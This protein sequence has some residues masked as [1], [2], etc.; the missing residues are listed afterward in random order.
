MLGKKFYLHLELA[1]NLSPR[2]FA[3]VVNFVCCVA[4]DYYRFTVELVN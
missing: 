4:V 3:T 1:P 2:L